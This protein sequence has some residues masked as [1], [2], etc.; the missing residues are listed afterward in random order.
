MAGSTG[1]LVAV[2]G[3]TGTTGRACAVGGITTGLTDLDAFDRAYRSAL[4]VL[5]HSSHQECRR[6]DPLEQKSPKGLAYPQAVHVLLESLWDPGCSPSYL[7]NCNLTLKPSMFSMKF[8]HGT[9]NTS[10]ICRDSLA[11]HLLRFSIVQTLLTHKPADL[12]TRRK[13]WIDSKSTTTIF[14]VDQHSCKYALQP[15]RCLKKTGFGP[16]PNPVS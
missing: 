6:P 13:L 4:F 3:N 12:L 2:K 14:L 15:T 8:R 5:R 11:T 16:C 1:V 9:L 10:N 7:S